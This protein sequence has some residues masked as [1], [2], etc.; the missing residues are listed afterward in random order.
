MPKFIIPNEVVE[1]E[2]G[3]RDDVFPKGTWEGTIEKLHLRTITQGEGGDFFLKTKEGVYFA[4]ECEVANLQVGEV[5]AVLDGQPNIGGMKYFESDI[6]LS[7]DGVNWDDYVPV[8]EDDRWR[9]RQTQLRLTKLA[10][11]LGLVEEGAEGV[12]PVD[13][14]GNFLRDTTESTGLGGMRVRFKVN[15]RTFKKR[16]GT[17]G[18]QALTAQ[19]YPAE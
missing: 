16:D 1:S 3:Q 18:K 7:F 2:S 4:E 6:F 5:V 11:A 17:E 14:F 12:G 19:F 10:K 8:E 13:E 15:H 9:L